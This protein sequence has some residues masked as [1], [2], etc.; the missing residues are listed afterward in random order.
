MIRLT[1]LATG[2]TPTALPPG[3][4]SIPSVTAPKP[5]SRAWSVPPSN[6]AASLLSTTH[7]RQVSGRFKKS[8]GFYHH[9]AFTSPFGLASTHAGVW[10]C[11][12]A[13]TLSGPL[14]PLAR[15]STPRLAPSFSRPLHQP[16]TGTPAG[17]DEMLFVRH[18]LSHGASWRTFDFLGFNVRRYRGKPLIKP[19][20]AAVR[21]IRERLRTELRSLRGTNAQAVIK[22]LNPIIRGWAAYY[23]TQVSGEVFDKLDHIPV[24]AHLQV[25]QIQPR[26]Q[27]GVLGVRPVLRQV[28]QG[29]A[30]PVGVRRP[31]QRR[32]HAQVL[33]DRIVRHQI[34]KQGAS[35]DDP[36]LAEYWAERRRK[37]RPCRSTR[38]ACGSSGPGRSLFDLQEPA[39]AEQPQNPHDWEQWLTPPARRSQI[40]TRVTGTSDEAEPRLIH[41]DADGGRHFARLR[42]IRACLSRMRGRP[43]RPVLR[44]ARHS[45]VPGL[46]GPEAVA[47][48][49]LPL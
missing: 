2:S 32:L 17:T 43:A 44:G 10:Q 24:A 30:R 1:G 21:R 15:A 47:N 31:P 3:T 22:R 4:R 26:E 48:I 20:K 18:L 40:A 25:G 41:A 7:V 8:R 45:N 6:K 28:Q 46:P 23:R 16:G 27:V 13:V 49:R 33:L 5:E 36:A 34:V 14:T 9:F 39:F 29:Q 42:A 37:A 19:S 35:P 38:P 12:P 11:R